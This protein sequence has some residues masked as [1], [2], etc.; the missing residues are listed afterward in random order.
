MRLEKV[1]T[2]ISDGKTQQAIDLLQEVLTGKDTQLLNQT[3]LLEGQLKDLQRK[4]QL[5]VQDAS[6]EL[7][8]INFTLLS[9]C[10]DAGN[11][12]N[13]GDDKIEKPVSEEANTTGLIGNSLAILGIII[14]IA[15]ALFVGFIFLGKSK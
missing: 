5:G 2:L 12:E 11:L 9:L 7:N 15:V 10:D 1:K 14:V 6:T 3:L 8:R 4:M 13:I